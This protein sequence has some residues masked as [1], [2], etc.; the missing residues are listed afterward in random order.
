MMNIRFRFDPEKL[1]QALTYFAGNGIDDL[2]KMKVAK[3]LF[4]ADKY[5]LLRY[6]RPVIGDSYACMEYGPVPSTSL[7]VLSDVIA[8]DPDYPPVA[9]TLFD[10]YIEVEKKGKYPV[11]RAKQAPDLEVFSDSDIEALNYTLSQ[12]GS[13]SAWQLSQESHDEPAWK[14][15]N[16]SRPEGSSVMMDYRLFFEGHPEAENI[17][18]LVELQQEDR[19]FASVMA[20]EADQG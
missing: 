12:H 20:W 5:H 11:F 16:E 3:L 4:H 1:V 19:D 15:A 9:K 14:I 8:G 17:L 7:N 13:K 6:G 2:D 18:R 10:A